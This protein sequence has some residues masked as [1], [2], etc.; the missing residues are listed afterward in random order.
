MAEHPDTVLVQRCL[1]GDLETYG[2]LVDRYSGRLISLAA[3]M[4]GNRHDAEDVAQDAFVR[5]FKAL[6]SFQR[7]AKFSSWLTQIAL[8][9]CKDY[10]KSKSRHA[11]SVEEEHLSEVG[12]E[13]RTR[14]PELIQQSE[15][16]EK[17]REC[18]AGLPY[19][20]R[21][22]FVLRHLHGEE[23]DEIAELTRTTPDTARVR[24]HRARELLREL[25]SP[26]VSTFWREKAAKD[27]PR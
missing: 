17:M 22:A 18:V 21:E 25:L 19:L 24:A 2:L 20:Y 13:T 1:D 8:N 14:A 9:L 7:R 11:R 26:S 27:G 4:I 12:D 3:M 5:A 23:Y 10:L 15:L 16:S 6:G